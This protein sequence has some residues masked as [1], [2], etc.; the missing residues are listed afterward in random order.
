MLWGAQI[1]LTPLDQKLQVVEVA[2]CFGAGCEQQRLYNLAANS[3]LSI[4]IIIY[5]NVTYSLACVRGC[6]KGCE[7]EYCMS[8]FGGLL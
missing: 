7:A 2:E 3:N 4:M 8:R 5:V 1:T 6:S